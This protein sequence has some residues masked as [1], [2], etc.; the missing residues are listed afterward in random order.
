MLGGQANNSSN[1]PEALKSV[2]AAVKLL[3]ANTV[4]VPVAWEQVEAEE[5]KFDFSFVD[6]L[7]TQARENDVRLVLLWFATWKNNGPNYA[8]AMGQA[9]QQAF[10]ARD[11][12]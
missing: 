11:H 5:G 2:W 12:R 8:P 10:P 3:G 7:L 1:Y 6:T 9:G 4:M